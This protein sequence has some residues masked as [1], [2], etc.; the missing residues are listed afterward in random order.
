[1]Q[2][3]GEALAIKRPTTYKNLI[4]RYRLLYQNFRVTAK[5]KS[6]IDNTYK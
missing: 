5:Q 4:Y 2:D 6:T 3:T 1:M